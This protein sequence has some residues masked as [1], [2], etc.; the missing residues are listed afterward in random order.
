MICPWVACSLADAP[1]NRHSH[2][3]NEYTGGST[4][5]HAAVL[6]VVVAYLKLCVSCRVLVRS[7]EYQV[8]IRIYDTQTCFEVYDRECDEIDISSCPDVLNRYQ[9]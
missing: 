9:V 4:T 2:S 8:G 1:R 3:S 7:T 6:G 5:A